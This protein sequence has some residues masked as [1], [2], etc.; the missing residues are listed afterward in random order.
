MALKVRGQLHAARGDNEAALGDIEQA[1]EII[2]RHLVIE[3]RPFQLT[4]RQVLIDRVVYDPEVL[5]TV[6][7]QRAS[8]SLDV[9]VEVGFLI[10][11]VLVAG[12]PTFGEHGRP[13]L[14]EALLGAVV[15]AGDAQ[16]EKLDRRGRHHLI[17]LGR[18]VV[19]DLGGEA[20]F[21]A[22]D[23]VFAHL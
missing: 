15:D 18:H 20:Y 6:S 7:R 23:V 11:V 14:V 16:R 5:E 8:D 21:F 3:I 22:G 19:G 4:K 9:L 1:I 13:G 12:S 10:V 17:I 2:N